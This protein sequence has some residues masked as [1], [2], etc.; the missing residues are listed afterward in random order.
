MAYH[1][2]SNGFVQRDN[3]KILDALRPVVNS[4][5][6]NWKDWLPY[7]TV[8]I[9]SPVSKS[10]GK[11]PHYI[12]ILYGGDKRLPYDLLTSPQKPVY[13]I[14]SYAK[15]QMRVFTDI[16][17]NVQKRLE[18][19]RGDTMA[20]QHKNAVKITIKVGD[21]IMVRLPERSFKLSPTF[22][23]PRLVVRQL[24]GNKSEVHDSIFNTV[25]VVH[26]D[27]LKKT[28]AQ[29]DPSLVDCVDLD[30]TIARTTYTTSANTTSA[31]ST[32]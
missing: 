14:D 28:R 15:Q 8:C 25:D 30:N 5:H 9:K 12:L 23:G 20:K 19:P 13:D 16:H 32:S 7:R 29:T 3:R 17:A 24:H 4:L 31:N 26:S 21:A 27:R 18:A 1:P 11:S 6:D 22:F 10:T 2:A